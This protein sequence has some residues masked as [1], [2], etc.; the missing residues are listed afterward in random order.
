M[1][2]RFGVPFLLLWLGQVVVENV[3]GVGVRT[4]IDILDGVGI[5][6][7]SADGGTRG[8]KVEAV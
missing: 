7:R 2:A 8:C 4:S 3:R 1:R 6:T 5:G